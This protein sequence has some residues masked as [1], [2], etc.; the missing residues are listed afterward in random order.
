MKL[1]RNLG[2]DG[3]LHFGGGRL[4]AGE[5]AH[6]AAAG[7][8]IEQREGPILLVAGLAGA[9]EHV[10]RSARKCGWREPLLPGQMWACLRS[11]SGGGNGNAARRAAAH[12]HACGLDTLP[13]AGIT[14]LSFLF[15]S[16]TA[17]VSQSRAD[18]NEH[19]DQLAF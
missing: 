7:A 12:G 14:L 16:A 2:A 10:M 17:A 3:A 18:T 9:D 4:E 1:S 11:R 13:R 5:G 6:Q 8:P 19:C 15:L